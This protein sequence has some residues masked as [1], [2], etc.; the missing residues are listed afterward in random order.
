MKTL[1]AAVILTVLFAGGQVFA[2]ADHDEFQRII[3]ARCSQCHTP[4]RIE[5]A[6][7]RGE[8]FD[9]IMAKMI[10]FGARI[11]SREQEVLGVFWSGA[12]AVAPPAGEG[13]TVA[14]DPL[15]EY[16]AVLESRCTGCHSLDLVEKA[17]MEGR[18]MD[19]LVDMMV[20]RGAIITESEKS[21]LR[22]FW[23]TPFK[24]KLPE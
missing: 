15:G 3:D 22:P 17:M 21:A 2:Q 12:Q 19:E 10:R 14:G 24:Q 8:N 9:E 13:P 18:S 6:I 23:G 20:K 16:R 4:E 1:I 5:Y 7:Q 11:D